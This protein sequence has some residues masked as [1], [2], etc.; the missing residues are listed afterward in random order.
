M[1]GFNINTRKLNHNYNLF[2]KE[3]QHLHL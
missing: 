3:F 2:N 1:K